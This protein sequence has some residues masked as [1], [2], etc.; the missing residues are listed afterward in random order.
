MSLN[1]PEKHASFW[2]APLRKAGQIL[3]HRILKYVPLLGVERGY[4]FDVYIK[5][6][7]PPW[8]EQLG[9]DSLCERRCLQV[10]RCSLFLSPIEL[11]RDGH[12]WFIHAKEWNRCGNRHRKKNTEDIPVSFT[13][14]RRNSS[15]T[16]VHVY[17]FEQCLRSWSKS[18]AYAGR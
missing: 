6:V 13:W 15:G 3:R 5:S 1:A 9:D 14:R 11:I 18:D 10:R 17:C 12:R 7:I 2:C 8:M 4:T 16:Y